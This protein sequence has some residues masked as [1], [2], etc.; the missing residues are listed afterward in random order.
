[1]TFDTQPVLTSEMLHLRPLRA[2]DFEGLYAAARDPATWAGHPAKTRYQR[3][4]FSP[5]FASLQDSGSCLVAEDRSALRIIGCS[6]YYTAPD[7]PGS[8]SIGFTFLDHAYWGGAVNFEMKRLMLGHAFRSFDEVWFH[9][10]PTNI[11]S[12]KATAKLGAVFV[13]DAALKLGP[14]EAPWK[15]YRLTRDAWAEVVAAKE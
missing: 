11:R 4:V 2:D 13:Y 15:C 5:Y 10:D 3:D 7:M 6:R 1:M 9:I 8:I 12:Q 14:A